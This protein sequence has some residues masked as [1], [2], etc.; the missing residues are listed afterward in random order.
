MFHFLKWEASLEEPSPATWF[1][2]LNKKTQNKFQFC[3]SD[4]RHIEKFEKAVFILTKSS[5]LI[6]KR[7]KWNKESQVQQLDSTH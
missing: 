7:G 2:S 3:Q 5:N 4:S 1:N 6:K